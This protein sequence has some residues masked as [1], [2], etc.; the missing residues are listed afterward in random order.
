MATSA[1]NPEIKNAAICGAIE[2][3]INPEYGNDWI[4]S[5]VLRDVSDETVGDQEEAVQIVDEII[6]DRFRAF[7]E[8]LVVE[9]PVDQRERY[10]EYLTK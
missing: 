7:V 10:A 4:L 6:T 5:D 8:L 2:I 1:V 9:L 3:L